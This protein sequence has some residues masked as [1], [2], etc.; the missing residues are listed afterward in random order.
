VTKTQQ[1]AAPASADVAA[2]RLL[3][4]ER[5]T[6]GRVT[7]GKTLSVAMQPTTA[8]VSLDL[9]WQRRES[10]R[11][12]EHHLTPPG[13]SRYTWDDYMAPTN[14]KDDLFCSLMVFEPQGF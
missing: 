5:T 6:A 11:F 2:D 12:T 8:A 1:V 7:I 9:G 4:P 14:P 3:S 13:G 10:E